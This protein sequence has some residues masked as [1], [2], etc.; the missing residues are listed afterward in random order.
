MITACKVLQSS[1]YGNYWPFANIT[2]C[3]IRKAQRKKE[4]MNPKLDVN[5]KRMMN[6]MLQICR[7]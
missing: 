3:L 6:G 1:K 2:Y 4:E 5:W 7:Y